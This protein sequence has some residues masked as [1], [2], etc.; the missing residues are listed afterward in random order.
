[1]FQGDDNC[2]D[3]P[4]GDEFIR[5]LNAEAKEHAIPIMGTFELT[6]RCNFNCK[7]CYVHLS[8]KRIPEFGRE[9]NAEEWIRLAEQ[10]RDAGMLSLC[11]TG[12]DPLLHPEF[13]TIY[14]ALAQMGFII[15]LQTN[16][17]ML[18]P[19]IL[20]LLDEYPPN[21]V[22]ITVYGSNDDVYR[23][24]CGVE[25][26][27]TRVDTG[28]RSLMALNIPV[29]LVTTVIK[30]NMHDLSKIHKY[31]QELGVPWIYSSAAYP[32]SRGAETDASQV[33]IDEMTATDYRADVK[34][35]L[36]LPPRK[37]N[38]K[39][40]DY[41]KGYR[42][43]FWI[44][45]DGK[46]R[47]CSFMNEPDIDILGDSFLPAWQKLVDYEEELRWPGECYNCEIHDVCRVC[48]GSLAA[49]SGSINRVNK[50]FCEKLKKYILK[51]REDF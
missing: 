50:S 44:T 29:F 31:T 48:A 40:C 4:A 36:M 23:D 10:A 26:G 51:E 1:M 5:R 38:D 18:S 37:P 43:S 20:R 13:E 14:R 3:F 9:M 16:A 47:F 8:E 15:T 39:P 35:M 49:R 45:W 24:V 27:F 21:E 22:K 2:N 6:P 11:I 17:S 32:S 42:I 19:N 30:Q 7:M 34:R 12:G 25:K 41:C 33:A 28:I 46:M